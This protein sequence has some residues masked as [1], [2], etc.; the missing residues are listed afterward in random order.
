MNRANYLLLSICVIQVLMTISC[1]GPE[2]TFDQQMIQKLKEECETSDEPIEYTIENEILQ[3][4]LSQPNADGYVVV[5]STTHPGITAT[6]EK[7]YEWFT[8]RI[9]NIEDYFSRY[10]P[11]ISSLMD[12]YLEN[13]AKPSV[14]SIKSCINVGYY[15]DHDFKF[16]QYYRYRRP[17]LL[18]A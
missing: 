4:F 12:K 15:I 10:N 16:E 3:K 18:S 9:Q 6:S 11:H 7:E 2:L 8:L 14:L 13:N 5:S 1:S 17:I